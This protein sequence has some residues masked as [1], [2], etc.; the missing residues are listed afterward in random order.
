MWPTKRGLCG[1][2][3][4][5]SQCQLIGSE[6]DGHG[7]WDAMVEAHGIHEWQQKVWG[8]VCTSVRECGKVAQHMGAE[9]GQMDGAVAN[10]LV[11]VA[12][13]ASCLVYDLITHCCKVGV[14]AS[15]HV[16]GELGILFICLN[17]PQVQNERASGAYPRATGQEVSPHLLMTVTGTLEAHE[18]AGGRLQV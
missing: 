11:R 9:D 1:T 10:V 17:P 16:H 6:R 5:V 3:A 2:A 4:V 12:K 13:Q 15:G 8:G 14:A 7:E 18:K